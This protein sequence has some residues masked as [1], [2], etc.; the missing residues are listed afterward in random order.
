M[1]WELGPAANFEK[2]REYEAR[3]EQVFPTLPLSG[4]CQYRR[5]T[6]P[7]GAVRDALVT[8]RF[9]LLKDGLL[10]RNPHF[11]SPQELLAGIRRP[12]TEEGEMLKS[13]G[14]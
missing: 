7:P 4:I 9:V 13:L 8:H 10:P 6:L 2:L 14:K 1:S 11:V 5:D 3:L 12:H